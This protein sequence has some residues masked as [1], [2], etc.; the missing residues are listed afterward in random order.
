MDELTFTYSLCKSF[1]QN[2][3]FFHCF[4]GK[5]SSRHSFLFVYFYSHSA[6]LKVKKNTC[7]TLGQNNGRQN[8]PLC[9]LKFMIIIVEYI[10]SCLPCVVAAVVVVDVVAI[11]VVDGTRTRKENEALRLFLL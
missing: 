8:T 1:C 10:A 7:P 5:D 9:Q 4:G 2:V 3:N 6:I 11:V